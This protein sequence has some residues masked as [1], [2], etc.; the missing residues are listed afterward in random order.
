MFSNKKRLFFVVTIAA[1]GL[2]ACGN[3]PINAVKKS[4]ID[5]AKTTTVENALTSREVCKSEKWNS[6][7]DERGRTVVNYICEVVDGNDFLKKKRDDH[8]DY[9]TKDTQNSLRI[10]INNYEK[11][12]AKLED[13]FSD[14]RA[15]IEQIKEKIAEKQAMPPASFTYEQKSILANLEIQLKTNEN[16]LSEWRKST[17]SAMKSAQDWVKNA[18]TRSENSAI[19]E[20]ALNKYPIYEDT[21]ENFQW[22]VNQDNEVKL[23]Y[24]EV[25]AMQQG[26]EKV[27]ILKYNK[28][29]SILILI[30][31][32]KSKEFLSYLNEIQNYS[33]MHLFLR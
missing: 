5:G 26:G 2:S 31:N 33:M 18:Q 11:I 21:H 6:F 23:V 10:E 1:I 28:P 4:Y 22:I 12:K 30:S 19:Q 14:Q 13:D 16:L 7:K 25:E 15:R 17:E 29:E 3:D 24:G 27:Q 8:I 32:S 9:L 20:K